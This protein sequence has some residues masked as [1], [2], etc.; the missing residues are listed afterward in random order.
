M[1][2][3]LGTREQ[4]KQRT[5][6]AID[7]AAWRLFTR[8]GFDDTTVEE[9]AAAVGIAPRTFFRYFETKDAV[10]YGDWRDKLES[11][12]RLVEARPADESP[13]DAMA[14][15]LADVADELIGDTAELLQRSRI[16]DGSSAAGTYRLDVV[17]PVSIEALAAVFGRRLGVDPDLDVRPRLFAAG[18]IA[19]V[20]I[21]R[22]VWLSTGGRRPLPHVVAEAFA[23]LGHPFPG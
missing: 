11:V 3:A 5:R 6:A 17:Q 21:A 8:Q 1:Q 7:A 19:A 2:I 14:A 20:E 9:I 12:C 16:I 15:V 18:A 22:D 4:R 23:E 13:L 10:L